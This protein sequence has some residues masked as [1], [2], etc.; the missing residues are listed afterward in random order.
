MYKRYFIH[1][2]FEIVNKK[3]ITI[4]IINHA[5]SKW[6]VECLF[7]RHIRIFRCFYICHINKLNIQCIVICAFI[8]ISCF[9]IFLFF[10]FLSF[11]LLFLQFFAMILFRIFVSM[12]R[13]MILKI[14]RYFLI[15]FFVIFSKKHFLFIQK[16][17]HLWLYVSIFWIHAFYHRRII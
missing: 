11:D 3:I 2:M 17:S 8:V 15:E 9:V 14:D 1:E 4:K 7:N 12:I 5:F 16:I 13:L 10:S 6:I